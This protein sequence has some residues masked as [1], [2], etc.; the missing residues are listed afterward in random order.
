MAEDTSMSVGSCFTILTE[1]LGMCCAS[2]AEHLHR[3]NETNW[4]ERKCYEIKYY[5]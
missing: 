3:P 1:N 2:A 5:G 4:T